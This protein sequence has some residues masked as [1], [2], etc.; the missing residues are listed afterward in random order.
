MVTKIQTL[1]IVKMITITSI[2]II[3]IIIMIM[4]IIMIDMIAIIGITAITSPSLLMVLRLQLLFVS[5]LLV[6]PSLSLTI[7]IITAIII[8]RVNDIVDNVNGCY[9]SGYD[10]I[11]F[12]LKISLVSEHT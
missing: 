4:K 3:S 11:I 10:H 2:V 7:A 5:L 1:I 12:Q 8:S 9:N 6:Q